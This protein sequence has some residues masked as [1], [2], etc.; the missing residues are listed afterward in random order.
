MV[1]YLVLAHLLGDFVL[2]TDWMVRRRDDLRV[3]TLH[4]GIHFALMVLLIGSLRSVIWPYL[5]LLALIHLG[6]DRIKNNITN[7]RPDWTK[8]FFVIDQALHFAVIFLLVWW[9][10]KE[11]GLL[12]IPGKHELVM[13]AIAFLFISYVWF[14]VE[15]IFNLSNTDYLQDLNSTKFPRMLTR[16]GLVS[17]FLLIQVWFTSGMAVVFSNP[18]PQK[19][20]RQRA[21]LT[22]ISVSLFAIFFLSWALG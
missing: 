12:P 15:R 6:Q 19:K 17:L 4:A 16:V 11:S 13:I 20:F 14:I 8:P 22:D 9:F 7:Q 2:Q 3:L 10:Q 21:V 1:W 5:L 18:Y